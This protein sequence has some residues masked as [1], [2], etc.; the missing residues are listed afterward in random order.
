MPDGRVGQ[1]AVR[2]RRPWTVDQAHVGRTHVWVHAR[3][4]RTRDPVQRI[5]RL[6]AIPA[7]YLLFLLLF[8][9][10]MS[11]IAGIARAI[12]AIPSMS[13]SRNSRNSKTWNSW[14]YFSDQC[15][16]TR[17]DQLSGR[18]LEPRPTLQ[19]RRMASTPRRLDAHGAW[20]HCTV[21]TLS[22]LD[23]SS[24]LQPRRGLDAR[25]DAAST[26]RRQGSGTYDNS[27]LGLQSVLSAALRC[28]CDV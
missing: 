23:A 13:V 15:T 16:V 22:Y 28:E 5:P 12:P 20:S 10:P 26:A 25:L 14:S 19:P 18:T 17:D 7:A 6:C 3:H 27:L 1:A 11:G 2:A 8:R 9:V 24:T 4:A 21:P